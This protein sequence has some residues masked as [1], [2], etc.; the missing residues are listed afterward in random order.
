MLAAG[1][2]TTQRCCKIKSERAAW[3]ENQNTEKLEACGT[4]THFVREQHVRLVRKGNTRTLRSLGQQVTGYARSC[5][6][7]GQKVSRQQRAEQQRSRE[8]ARQ[9]AR[10]YESRSVD[11]ELLSF[12]ARSLLDRSATK[13]DMVGL[14]HAWVSF[15][16]VWFFNRVGNPCKPC[17][18]SRTRSRN[19]PRQPCLQQTALVENLTAQNKGFGDARPRRLTKSAFTNGFLTI[20]CDLRLRF[21]QAFCAHQVRG[22][23][24]Q[25]IL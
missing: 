4:V 18:P 21:C 3:V 13:K 14:E 7:E 25:S 2:F 22:D 6:G 12:S 17:G 8:P 11:G 10:A 24:E 1:G 20:R 23:T 16:L 5:A 15:F 9:Q 19:I